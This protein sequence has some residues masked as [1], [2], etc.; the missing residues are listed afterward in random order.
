MLQIPAEIRKWATLIIFA[1]VVVLIFSVL[2][3]C[4]QRDERRKAEG[5]RNL[6]EGRTVSAVEAINEIGKLN[7]RGEVTDREV[8]DAHDKIRK[9]SPDDRSRIARYELCRLQHRTD[10]DGL[11]NPG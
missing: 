8:Q 10:C 3:M 7:E 9:A 4:H 2:S 6:A 5:E 1:L 11:L